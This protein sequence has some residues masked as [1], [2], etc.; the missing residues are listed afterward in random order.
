M[1]NTILQAVVLTEGDVVTSSDLQLQEG[2]GSQSGAAHFRVMEQERA[3]SAS[4]SSRPLVARHDADTPCFDEAWR[5]LGGRL[6]V[7]VAAATASGSPLGLPL[8]KWL[9]HDLVL[10]A[11]EQ[12]GRVMARA[13]AR[14]GLPET[15]FARHLRQAEADA[16][17]TRQP[18]SWAS[19]RSGLS[20]L[21]RAPGRPSGNLADQ[22]DDLLFGL[23]I[24]SVPH[25]MSQAAGLMGVSVPT[26]KRRV[27]DVR[28]FEGHLNVCA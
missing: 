18:E 23:V 25:R 16:A 26:M 2:S 28:Q 8:G 7:E 27:A 4:P 3:S 22:V 5:T 13:A 15:T 21:L 1:Q 6:A 14:V 12:S 19:V 20:D 11:Y 24:A 10:E 9:G 17:S